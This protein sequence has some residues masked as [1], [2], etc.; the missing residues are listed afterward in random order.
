MRRLL[1]MIERRI[2]LWNTIAGEKY[3]AVVKIV[4]RIA[5]AGH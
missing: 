1:K 5:M 3:Q 2:Y 4:K